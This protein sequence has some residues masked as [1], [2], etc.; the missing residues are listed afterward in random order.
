MAIKVQ[1]Q[2]LYQDA[3]QIDLTLVVCVRLTP[4]RREYSEV[5]ALYVKRKR[6]LAPVNILKDNKS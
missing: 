5:V 4:G 2:L 6:E 1:H 3:K